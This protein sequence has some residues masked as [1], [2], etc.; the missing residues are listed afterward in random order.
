MQAIAIP[1]DSSFVQLSE[2]ALKSGFY[3]GYTRFRIVTYH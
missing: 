3:G 1:G 2:N